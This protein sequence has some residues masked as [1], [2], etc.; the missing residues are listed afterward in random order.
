MTISKEDTRERVPVG[1]NSLTLKTPGVLMKRQRIEFR[2]HGVYCLLA[3]GASD[4][5]CGDAGQSVNN[6]L[7]FIELTE[8]FVQYNHNVDIVV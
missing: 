5:S 6:L 8:G 4:G 1:V 7:E 2:C 3:H